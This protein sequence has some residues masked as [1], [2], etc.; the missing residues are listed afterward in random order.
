MSKQQLIIIILGCLLL[1]I[2]FGIKIKA[3][4]ETIAK[5]EYELDKQ[6]A[7]KEKE[8]K[9]LKK[10]ISGL[11]Q[12][13]EQ[14]E[15]I[16]NNKASELEKKTSELEN[17]EKEISQQKEIQ[18]KQLQDHEK[19]RDTIRVMSSR[20]TKPQRYTTPPDI[21][22]STDKLTYVGKWIVTFYT[23]SIEECSSNAGITASGAPVAPSYT[24]AVDN[25][26]WNFGD[27]FYVEGWGIVEAKDTGGAIK[28]RNRADICIFDRDIAKKLGKRKLNVYKIN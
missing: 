10:E 8:K 6:I 28:G 4:S 9:E 12:A 2:P 19:L 21:S 25:R 24:I 15:K 14:T 11:K 17:K 16:A 23:P 22:V 20:G 18:K 1:C 5:L 13:L 7:E 3:D 27:K 26:Y